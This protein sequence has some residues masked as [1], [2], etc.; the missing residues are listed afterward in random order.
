MRNFSTSLLILFVIAVMGGIYQV[1]NIEFFEAS[2]SGHVLKNGQ[3]LN[4]SEMKVKLLKHHDRFIVEMDYNYL[5]KPDPV[6]SALLN[7]KLILSCTYPDFEPIKVSQGRVAY[8]LK[9]EM[10]SESCARTKI[11]FDDMD[12][13]KLQLTSGTVIDL[14]RIPVRDMFISNQQES[15]YKKLVA[16]L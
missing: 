4:N 1:S 10:P 15:I 8:D 11:V 6:V 14:K 3:P 16:T 13:A 5:D 2:Y 9:E 7:G 12:N